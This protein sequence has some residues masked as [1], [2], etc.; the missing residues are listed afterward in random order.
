MGGQQST[1]SQ[2]F[3]STYRHIVMLGLDCAG[4]TT[5]LYRMKLEQYMNTVPTIGF[6]CEKVKGHIGKSKGVSFTIWD[7]GGQDKL[8]PL[9]NTYM[10]HTEGIIFVVDSCDCERFEEAKIELSAE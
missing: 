2:L 10:H 7:I 5:V 3:T 8:R 1:F 9:W 6:N 4:K